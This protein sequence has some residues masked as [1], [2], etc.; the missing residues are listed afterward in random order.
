MRRS[1]FVNSRR[2]RREALQIKSSDEVAHASP[3]S[4]SSWWAELVIGTISPGQLLRLARHDPPL[5]TPARY[6]TYRLINVCHVQ[7]R[8]LRLIQTQSLG[9]SL[10]AQQGPSPTAPPWCRATTMQ[11]T[12]LRALRVAAQARTMDHVGQL[13]PNHRVAPGLVKPD[14]AWMLRK[15]GSPIRDSAPLACLACLA[16]RTHKHLYQASCATKSLCTFLVA[17]RHLTV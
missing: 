17:W 5:S 14:A 3:H 12:A 16:I 4:C 2:N 7:L 10:I 15:P 13:A 9:R 8:T 1:T 6:R 11:P